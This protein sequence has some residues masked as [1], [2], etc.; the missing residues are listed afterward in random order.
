MKRISNVWDLV[1]IIALFVGYITMVACVSRTQTLDPA[2]PYKGDMLLWS[3]DN[4]LVQID[5]NLD[6][7]EQF[8]ARNPAVMTHTDV[9]LMVTKLALLR[10]GKVDRNEDGTIKDYEVL[11]KLFVARDAYE[12]AKNEL[13]TVDL[14]NK[15][16]AASLILTQVHALLPLF[17]AP[18]AAPVTAEPAALPLELEPAL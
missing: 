6:M 5:E 17:V 8:V 12:K 10:D 13:T 4:T 3:V 7:V 15:T 1:A 9:Y 18:P 11:A 16:K 14:Q 2:G